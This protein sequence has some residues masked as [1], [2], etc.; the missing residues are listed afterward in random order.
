M[1]TMDPRAEGPEPVGVPDPAPREQISPDGAAHSQA[2]HEQP[3]PHDHEHAH[4]SAADIAATYS[5]VDQEV[6]PAS[7]DRPPVRLSRWSR[8]LLAASAVVVLV[9]TLAHLGFMFLG[10]APSNSV[11]ASLT[12]SVSWYNALWTNEP[13]LEQNWQLFAPNPLSTNP[14]LKVRARSASGQQSGWFDLTGQ[15]YADTLHN[16]MPSHLT[17]NELRRAYSAYDASM[18]SQ[19][20]PA[21]TYQKLVTEYLRNICLHRVQGKVP[22]PIATLQ[23]SVAIQQIPPPGQPQVTPTTTQ[24]PWW[25][26]VGA[27]G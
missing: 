25:P 6:D 21:T 12:S 10:A 1:N 20:M 27:I 13:F 18:G 3:E 26:A 23:L 7:T 19:T 14:E 16:P 4:G 24:L 2:D 5:D 17:Q 15:D 8:V 9:L 11:S 22:F